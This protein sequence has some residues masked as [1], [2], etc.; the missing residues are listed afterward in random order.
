MEIPPTTGEVQPE[1]ILTGNDLI[2]G[3]DGNDVI[4]DFYG[5]NVIHG[6]SGNDDVFTGSGKDMLYGGLG[7][8][9]LY[10]GEG[11]DTLHGGDGNDALDGGY[12]ADII[13]G[14]SGNDQIDG[15]SRFSLFGIKSS[16]NDT[17]FGEDG[18]DLLISKTYRNGI[19]QLYGGTGNDTLI[20]GTDDLLYGGTGDDQIQVEAN[21]VDVRD[22]G[23]ISHIYGGLGT[24][25]FDFTQSY[26]E[27]PNAFIHRSIIYDYTL[28]ETVNFH[29]NDSFAAESAEWRV[30]AEAASYGG[31]NAV[32]LDLVIEGQSF[33]QVTLV[34]VTLE[35]YQAALA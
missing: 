10:S 2:F 4:Q 31:A 7:D 26:F 34:G 21:G 28:G 29:V 27:F 20:G 16:N 17:L 5:K 18:D 6:E 19:D 33:Y 25:Q 8:D 15:G 35:Q 30:D 9:S 23:V 13:R 32:N 22:A 12:G 11:A 24:D 1:T 3:G 14:G